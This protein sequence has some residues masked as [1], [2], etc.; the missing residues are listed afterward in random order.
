MKVTIDLENLDYLV[1][2]SLEE[3]TKDSVQTAVDTIVKARVEEKYG[4][5]IDN[6]VTTMM[7]DSI[8]N[9]LETTELTVGDS[10]TGDVQT[11][12]PKQY[13]NNKISQIFNDKAFKNTVKDGYYGGSR[14]ET[15]TFEQWL[16]REF[17]ADKLIK[18]HLTQFAKDTKKEISDHMKD[19]YNKELQSTLCDSIV[20]II[21]QNKEFKNINDNIKR[22]GE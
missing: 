11:V 7:E 13:I 15:V 22:L 8:R 12:T 20:D 18:E 10:F 19:T 16:K 21:M 3:T 5:T 9:Y 17:D 14:T 2:K 4:E 6:L 1:E